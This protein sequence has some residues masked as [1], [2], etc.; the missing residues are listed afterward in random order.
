MQELLEKYLPNISV[1][2]PEFIKAIQDTLKM[3]AISGIIVFIFGV[4]LGVLLIIS[5][6]GGIL[7][8]TGVY[9]VIDKV[10]NAFRSIPFIILISLLLPLTRAIVH[11]S[12]GVKG[13][14]IP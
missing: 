13:A 7:E 4:L 1:R 5:K 2:V 6:H 10:I 3:V 8:Q 9:H 11:T 14:V 12:I